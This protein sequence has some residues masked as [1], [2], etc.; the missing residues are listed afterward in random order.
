MVNHFSKHFVLI[1][2]NIIDKLVLFL[3]FG[4]HA[5]LFSWVLYD[6]KLQSILF[7]LLKW[8]E[9]FL[10]ARYFMNLAKCKIECESK[11]CLFKWLYKHS[12]SYFTNPSSVEWYVRFSHNVPRY[13]A[14]QPVRHVPLLC[15][16]W[17]T[18]RQCPHV[19]T[20]SLP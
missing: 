5:Y 16:H 19:S 8:I 13:P 11:L 14:S 6:E 18:S 15:K 17:F 2:F 1:K 7:L 4:F 10:Y 9:C 3:S 12:F 20:Q